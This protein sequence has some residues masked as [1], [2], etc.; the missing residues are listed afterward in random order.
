[1]SHS[2][3]FCN[4]GS[5]NEYMTF[6]G[7]GRIFTK[8]VHEII[9][10]DTG[11]IY[12]GKNVQ[13]AKKLYSDA[14]EPSI[15]L[16]AIKQPSKLESAINDEDS[17]LSIADRLK[18]RYNSMDARNAATIHKEIKNNDKPI[19]FL[20]DKV[21]T[22]DEKERVKVNSF[23]KKD[24]LK[25][26]VNQ[27]QAES[28]KE[29]FS[30]GEA[31]PTHALTYGDKMTMRHYPLSRNA[32]K[33]PKYDGG[34]EINNY[35]E[36][37][38]LKSAFHRKE[39]KSEN[40]PSNKYLKVKSEKDQSM[41]NPKKSD[42]EVLHTI[43]RLPN[44]STEDQ[45]AL[46]N[47]F[48]KAYENST[49]RSFEEGLTLFDDSSHGSQKTLF[50]YNDAKLRDD[51]LDHLKYDD[52]IAE[53][54]E[55]THQRKYVKNQ[56][57]RQKL[58]NGN[59]IND[60]T[61]FIDDN[62]N[63][64]STSFHESSHETGKLPLEIMTA[65]RS[66]ENQVIGAAVTNHYKNEPKTFNEEQIGKIHSPEE[67]DENELQQ[68]KTPINTIVPAF[69]KNGPEFPDKLL[70][71]EPIKEELNLETPLYFLSPKNE[72]E[73]S[74]ELQDR[75]KDMVHKEI[76]ETLNHFLF[77]PK[78]HQDY[79]KFFKK[80]NSQAND[81]QV[82]SEDVKQESIIN[83]S[84]ESS[85]E[86]DEVSY[87]SDSKL[88][89]KLFSQGNNNQH[90]TTDDEESSLTNS[91]NHF[92]S[93]SKVDSSMFEN[94]NNKDLQIKDKHRK[95]VSLEE[96]SY[97]FKKKRKDS[98][99]AT[100]L[101]NVTKFDPSRLIASLPDDSKEDGLVPNKFH[102][103]K[104]SNNKVDEKMFLD[105]RETEEMGQ[106]KANNFA[107]NSPNFQPES[108]A[109]DIKLSFGFSKKREKLIKK[110]RNP[111]VQEKEKEKEKE[112]KLVQLVQSEEKG[113]NSFI[114]DNDFKNN[115]KNTTKQDELYRIKKNESES[116][117]EQALLKEALSRIS[118]T[119]AD[120]TKKKSDSQKLID[121]I[122]ATNTLGIN[123][124]EHV[125]SSLIQQD[126]SSNN[127][128]EPSEEE[129]IKSLVDTNEL[130][131]SQILAKLNKNDSIK[132][133]PNADLPSKPTIFDNS[134]DVDL[135]ESKLTD[136]K[137]ISKLLDKN[138]CKRYKVTKNKG[139][140]RKKHCIE[141]VST[142]ALL[143]KIMLFVFQILL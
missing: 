30:V 59:P 45:T 40:L 85:K 41:E 89:Y 133:L 53:H 88:H 123:F 116:S 122:K 56:Q 106:K 21:D 51:Y 128:A 94:F 32:L 14:E 62:K 107:D 65:N 7:S 77:E 8:F 46:K 2:V 96:Q 111:K 100:E 108:V 95:E 38:S 37:V 6:G 28:D 49:D 13:R 110:Q 139:K 92:K 127:I 17:D 9:V 33:E 15:I 60:Q 102:F 86:N 99:P 105:N 113:T 43:E 35:A 75:M 72:N 120:E 3:I 19:E 71:S 97:K 115:N 4:L 98:P 10:N 80:G 44:V 52:K 50:K 11:K 24:P 12:G 64:K 27:M 136:D 91:E 130:L 26:S 76:N 125:N 1:M 112:S 54:H 109:S 78:T 132:E 74:E 93:F 67:Y 25:T 69:I 104:L 70:G 57:H 141:Q 90:K 119:E 143:W 66:D 48:E 73:I 118:S 23:N 5:G 117:K 101:Q 135:H 58:E 84:N 114:T 79:T 68:G 18:D 121:N 129:L 61:N 36:P 82:K 81:W 29:K 83:N 134:N 34:I 22:K 124:V 42:E 55:L 20:K 31:Q 103:K 140:S 16:K 126:S 131:D 137:V 87:G 63:V 142:Y 39:M 138:E 47:I